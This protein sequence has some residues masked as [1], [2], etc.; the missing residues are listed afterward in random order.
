MGQDRALVPAARKIEILPNP[1][2]RG[3]H[4]A[5]GSNLVAALTK[6][7]RVWGEAA[8]DGWPEGPQP[9]GLHCGG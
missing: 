2:T 5:A 7:Q 6:N 1:G 8:S 3:E 9:E 4:E